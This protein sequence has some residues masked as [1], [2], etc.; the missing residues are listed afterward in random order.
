ME[1][2]GPHGTLRI[3]AHIP[4]GAHLT[5]DLCQCA[6]VAMQMSQTRPLWMWYIHEDQARL[7]AQLIAWRGIFGAHPPPTPGWRPEDI[8]KDEAF[9]ERVREL[10]YQSIGEAVMGALGVRLPAAIHSRQRPT[11]I[12]F[13]YTPPKDAGADHADALCTIGKVMIQLDRRGGD[14]ASLQGRVEIGNPTDLDLDA[15]RVQVRLRGPDGGL[16]TVENAYI[17]TVIAKTT[18][19]VDVKAALSLGPAEVQTLDVACEVLLGHT[20]RFDARIIEV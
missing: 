5:R 1:A 17:Q 9:D 16:V 4:Q 2:L 12:L 6:A 3:R 8:R 19:I 7:P 14:P 18:R 11:L 10:L 20:V 13:E 15:V